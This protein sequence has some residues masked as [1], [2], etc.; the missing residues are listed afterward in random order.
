MKMQQQWSNNQLGFFKIIG[1]VVAGVIILA[2]FN[3]DA[4]AIVENSAVQKIWSVLQAIAGWFKG[5]F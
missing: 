5:F 1:L 4:R 2:Y 3:V